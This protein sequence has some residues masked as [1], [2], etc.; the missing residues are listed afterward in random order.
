MMHLLAMGKEGDGG[1]RRGKGTA[2]DVHAIIAK[3]H[4]VD[5]EVWGAK[6]RA[7]VTEDLGCLLEVNCMI[8]SQH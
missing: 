3:L 5:T 2:S 1:R 7:L 8:D 4:E 6:A